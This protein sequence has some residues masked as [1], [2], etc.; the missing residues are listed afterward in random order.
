ML[1]ININVYETVILAVTHLHCPN[2]TTTTVLRPFSGS[3]RVSQ[4][5]MR[6]SGRYGASK[7]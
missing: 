2:Q 1:T 5:Q 7:D 4:C 3:T 6:T